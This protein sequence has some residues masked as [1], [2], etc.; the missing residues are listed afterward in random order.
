MN[1]T[2][3]TR[4]THF[5]TLLRRTH[6]LSLVSIS[7]P[8]PPL[9]RFFA[10]RCNSSNPLPTGVNIRIPQKNDDFAMENFEVEVRNP[11]FPS[12]RLSL[13]DQA[14]FLLTF[15]AC[16]ATASFIG[17]VM[18]AAP[19][20]YAMSRTAIAV[21]KLADTARE[22]LPSTMAAIRLSGM[23]V[24]DLTLELTDLSQEISDGVN[25]S[26]QVVQA[27]EAGV[28]Q[29]GSLA[30]QKTLS[31]IEERANLPAISLQ[32]VVAGVAKKTSEAV[33]HAGK[34][35]MNIISG[36]RGGSTSL[37]DERVDI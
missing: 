19:T 24:S 20:L 30:R 33:G 35:F 18:A 5:P 25:K 21:A 8:S 27:A 2:S 3:I 10:V 22:E 14:F 12:P 9:H 17:F 23:E 26:A 15:T 32:P 16:T 7:A 11:R 28:R 6:R 34:T 13:G 1:P 37:G 29:I 31:M 4:P 36:S